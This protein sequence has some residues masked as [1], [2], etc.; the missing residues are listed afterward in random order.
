MDA[1]ERFGQNQKPTNPKNL[2]HGP[3]DVIDCHM[4]TQLVKLNEAICWISKVKRIFKMFE[5]HA[6]WTINQKV[7]HVKNVDL[8]K[9]MES[10]KSKSC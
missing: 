8:K 3:K 4:G 10:S 1:I 9:S 2:N 6:R 5:N 7:K